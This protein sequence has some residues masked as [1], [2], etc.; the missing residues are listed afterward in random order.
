VIDLINFDMEDGEVPIPT[1]PSQRDTQPELMQVVPFIVQDSDTVFNGV[2]YIRIGQGYNQCY[3]ENTVMGLQPPVSTLSFPG[4]RGLMA[5]DLQ[6]LQQ[7]QDLINQISQHQ[8]QPDIICA[9]EFIG[10]IHAL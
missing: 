5:H 9:S 1:T 2:D 7:V 8:R 3:V 6:D 10:Q 4:G